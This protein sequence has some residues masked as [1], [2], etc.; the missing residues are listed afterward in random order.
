LSPAHAA[1]GVRNLAL[2]AHV[3]SSVGWL[4]A[5]TAFLALALAGL[6]SADSEV[7]RAAYVAMEL[8]T[9]LVIV[10]LSAAS[11]VTGV[12]QSLIT[13]WGLFRHY[14]VVAK[15]AIGLFATLLLLFH[16]QVVGQ[17]AS[18]AL[19]PQFDTVSSTPRLRI[20]LVADAIGACVALLIATALSVYKPRGLTACGQATM[21]AGAGSSAAPSRADDV[22]LRTTLLL[23]AAGLLLLVGLLHLAGL[24]LHD[25]SD[26]AS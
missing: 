25:H 21:P 7:V 22:R 2:T 23:V 11:L 1:V 19:Q 3:T 12:V 26:D 5:V 9:W 18:L 4:G 6:T 15:L 14:W 17:M 24:G 10:P 16:T 8:T 13:P 20:H